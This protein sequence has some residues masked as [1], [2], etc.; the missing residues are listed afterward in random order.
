[1]GS[2]FIYL[3]SLHLCE[4]APQVFILISIYEPVLPVISLS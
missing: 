4:G 2:I 3:L 1:M